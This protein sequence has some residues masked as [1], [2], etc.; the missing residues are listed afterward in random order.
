VV[1][2]WDGRTGEVQATLQGH[3]RPVMRAV[4]SRDG[5][6]VVSGGFDGTLRVWRWAEPQEAGALPDDG[7]VVSA[8]GFSGDGGGGL[9]VVGSDRT[10]KVWDLAAAAVTRA[11]PGL[12]GQ[13]GMAALSRDGGR[14]VWGGRNGPLVVTDAADGRALHVLAGH[15]GVINAVAF[16]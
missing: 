8:L 16:S 2:V 5:R 1:R 7:R 3:T 14:L 6:R 10:V 13:S 9:V 11:L 12:R 15:Q 4:L